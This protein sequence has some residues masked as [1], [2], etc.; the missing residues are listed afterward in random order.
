MLIMTMVVAA[1]LLR[2]VF[3]FTKMVME[4]TMMLIAMLMLMSTAA[5]S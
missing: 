1:L 5:C 2:L 4:K 3:R